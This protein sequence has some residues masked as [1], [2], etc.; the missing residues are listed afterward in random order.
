[1]V[2][3]FVGLGALV[4]A[5]IIFVLW[6]IRNSPEGHEDARGFRQGPIDRP[7]DP[8]EEKK[9]AAQTKRAMVVRTTSI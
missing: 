5:C 6:L 1:M 2:A 9:D 3:I 8:P 7:A 4:G